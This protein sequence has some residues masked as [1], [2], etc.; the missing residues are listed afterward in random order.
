[1][2]RRSA[3]AVN[4]NVPK[5]RMKNDW[6]GSFHEEFYISSAK[7]IEVS[8]LVLRRAPPFTRWR[9]L[10]RE[11]DGKGDKSDTTPLS[12]SFLVRERVTR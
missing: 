6:S 12:P 5:V 1:M 10:E 2:K 3:I 4:Y 8:G 11:R 9:K 7:V